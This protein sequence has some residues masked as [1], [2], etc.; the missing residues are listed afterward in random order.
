MNLFFDFSTY[1]PGLVFQT[2]SG[3]VGR[4]VPILSVQPMPRNADQFIVCSRSNTIAIMNMQG[5]VSLFCFDFS[6]YNDL[7]SNTV[8]TTRVH[9]SGYSKLYK[10]KT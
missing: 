6:T 4:E 10:W 5:Q 8:L 3:L 9:I 2:I 1:L 7:S